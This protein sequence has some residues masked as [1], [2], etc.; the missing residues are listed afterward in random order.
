MM[1]ENE[2]HAHASGMGCIDVGIVI[3]CTRTRTRTS[4]RIDYISTIIVIVIHV[5]MVNEI[6]LEVVILTGT[7]IDIRLSHPRA[8]K[9]RCKEP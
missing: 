2:R 4:T 8:A 9:M 1:P 5:D 3:D 6:F 7:D